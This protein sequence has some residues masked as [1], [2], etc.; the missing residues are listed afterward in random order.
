MQVRLCINDGIIGGDK[1]RNICYVF[2]QT[3]FFCF[4]QRKQYDEYYYKKEID[5]NITLEN[6]QKLM[7]LDYTIKMNNN[8]MEIK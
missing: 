4:E 1:V 6:I 7:D 2:G 3:L 5:L 8:I